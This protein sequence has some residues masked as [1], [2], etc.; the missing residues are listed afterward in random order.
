MR[1][2][3]QKRNSF[4]EMIEKFAQRHGLATD[5]DYKSY[6]PEKLWVFV[7][8]PR[9]LGALEYLVRFDEAVSLSEAAA[10]IMADALVKF[11]LD[12]TAHLPAIKNVIF[13]DPATIVV[14]N[15][16]TK[17]VVKCQPNDIYDPEKGMAMAITKKYLGNKGNFNDVFKKWLPKEKEETGDIS[18][19]EAIKRIGEAAAKFGFVFDSVKVTRKK[20]SE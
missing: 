18:L 6:E 3:D 13:N 7:R 5:F 1:I 20:E 15:D 17:T 10:P 4:I 16:G 14:W 2:T 9:H 12:E 19:E 11:D 8:G